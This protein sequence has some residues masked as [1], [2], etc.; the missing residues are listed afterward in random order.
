[1]RTRLHPLMLLPLLAATAACDQIDPF[2][3]DGVWRPTGANEHNLS[4]ML[5]RPSERVR[6]TDEPGALGATAA[7][8]V[9]RLR[10]DKVRTLPDVGV[11]R[12]ITLPGSQGGS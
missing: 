3:R 10:T 9:E 12:I 11:A 6:G 7:G 8:A 2:R 5:A 4:V 1:M